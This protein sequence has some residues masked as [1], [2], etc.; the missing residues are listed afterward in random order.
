MLTYEKVLE[1]FSDYLR[2]DECAEVV[3]THHGA[4]DQIP[5][6]RYVQLAL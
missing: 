3:S 5:G 4:R 6:G 1:I 2:E